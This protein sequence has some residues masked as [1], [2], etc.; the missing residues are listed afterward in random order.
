MTDDEGVFFLDKAH[1]SCCMQMVQQLMIVVK[2]VVAMVMVLMVMVV[3]V[4]VVVVMMV[5][6]PAGL[7]G[8][9]PTL[10]TSPVGA[11]E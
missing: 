1:D 8:F 9:Y 2:L 3:T 4:M 5:Y 10:S 11:N 6:P 7:C